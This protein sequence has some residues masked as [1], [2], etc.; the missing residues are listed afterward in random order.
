MLRSSIYVLGGLC[1]S[2]L[3]GHGT[4]ELR[5]REDAAKLAREADL[6]LHA[7]LER[8]PELA[9]IDAPRARMLLEDSLEL[10]AD[11]TQ[12]GRLAYAEALEEYQKGRAPRAQ[13]ALA[14]ARRVLPQAVELEVLAG[15]L[16]IAA[17]D[18]TGAAHFAAAAIALDAHDAHARL[19]AADAAADA[20]DARHAA[21]LLAGLIE[22]APT[23]GTFYNR[24]GLV[25]EALGQT[26]AAEADFER[27]CELDPS[28]PQPHINLGRLLRDQGHARQ[29]EQA[30][31]LAI[32]RGPGEAQAWLGRGLSRIAQ[33]DVE[34][35]ALDVQRARELAPAEPAPLLA[36]ADLDVWH[37][38]LDPAIERYRAAL[39]LSGH[40][41]VA[42]LKLGN[43]L[44]R[45]RDFVAA[46]GAFEHAIADQPGLAAAH[47][48]LGAALMGLGDA[49][50]AEKAFAS[51]ATLDARD[52]NPLLNLALLRTRMGDRRAAR[53]ARAQAQARASLVN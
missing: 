3:L 51:A 29:A 39:A 37:G 2:W 11:A 10:H 49:A 32:E 24:R 1:L 15:N 18:A 50:N 35:G 53:D 8:A 13:A 20:G 4:L 33:G 42:W 19:L 5:K 17:G 31:A 27:A 46:R 48:G 7:P 16:A 34:G 25:D 21:D 44:T 23:I 14:R 36:L 40:D 41:A 43:A 45:K 26:D 30:F 6:V 12:R 9:R 28:L 47:N 22:Q 38:Q 52:P